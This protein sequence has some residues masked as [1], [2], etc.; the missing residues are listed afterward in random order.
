MSSVSFSMSGIG[1]ALGRI[2]LDN[3]ACAER[4]GLSEDWMRRRIGIDRR[5]LL[6]EGET[7]LELATRAADAATRAGHLGRCHRGHDPHRR[8]QE[9]HPGVA[10]WQR[11]L[12]KPSGH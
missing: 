3:V 9:R 11:P 10:D 7:L 8:R 12:L 1:A 2:C 4:L 5:F 6:G